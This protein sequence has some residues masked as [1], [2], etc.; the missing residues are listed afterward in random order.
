MV[1]QNTYEAVGDIEAMD[2]TDAPTTREKPGIGKV[3]GAVLGM[4]ENKYN[5]LSVKDNSFYPHL[6]KFDSPVPF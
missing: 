6:K 3:F 5:K 4:T 1:L 2:I